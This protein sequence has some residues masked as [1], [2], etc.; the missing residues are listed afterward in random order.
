MST[1]FQGTL[2]D[3]HTLSLR[4]AKYFFRARCRCI[5]GSRGFDGRCPSVHVRHHTSPWLTWTRSPAC[6]FPGLLRGLV[7]NALSTTAGLRWSAQCAA[8]LKSQG[9]IHRVHP[10]ACG[11]ER[12]RYILLLF[13]FGRVKSCGH[14]CFIRDPC[15]SP[16]LGAV[17]PLFFHLIFQTACI[18]SV[19]SRIFVYSSSS[20]LNA[21]FSLI[22][23]GITESYF[24]KYR[25][26]STRSA[27]RWYGVSVTHMWLCCGYNTSVIWLPRPL[28]Y[29]TAS[30]L[31]FLFVLNLLIVL[32]ISSSYIRFAFSS[33]YQ[34]LSCLCGM[35]YIII[36]FW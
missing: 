11:H 15:M 9:T 3:S 36:W 8:D 7:R 2:R 6:L 5:G 1:L 4:F 18:V 22:F 20:F 13:E 19:L 25:S 31:R 28:S 21:G 23:S 33:P 30:W 27:F 35:G 29:S 17:A 10:P 14:Y 16:F 32:R 24:L 26:F 34:L 12:D